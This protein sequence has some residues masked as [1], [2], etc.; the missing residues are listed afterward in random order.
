MKQQILRQEGQQLIKVALLLPV[1][2]A[3]LGLALDVGNVYVHHRMVQNAADAAA[4]AAGMVL[5]QSGASVAT[6]TARYY[7][8]LHGYDNN[9]T[10][11][12]V[13]VSVPPASG[14]YAGNSHYIQVRIQETIT[15]IFAALVWH[16]TF[17]VSASGTAGWTMTGLGPPVI[18][19][20]EHQC[21]TLRMNGITQLLVNMGSI[22]VNSN[23]PD[24]VRLVGSAS[25]ITSDPTTIVGGYSLGPGATIMPPPITGAPVLPDPLANLPVPDIGSYPVRYGTPSDP[26]TLKITSTSNVTLEPGVYYGGIEISGSGNVTFNPGVYILAGTGLKITG[27]GRVTGNNV[28]FYN[29]ND[30][31]KPT[32]DGAMGSIQLAGSNQL[33]LTPPGSGPYA[34]VTLFQD[35]S[36][37]NEANIVGSIMLSALNGIVYMKNG[38]LN[39]TGATDT[40]VNFVIKE[41]EIVGNGYLDVKGYEG[42]GWT[43]IDSRLSE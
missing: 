11:N 3:F 36:N 17:Q 28:F 31:S 34:G 40:Y 8:N 7:A 37:T 10:T 14:A 4:S 24:A 6:A 15:P 21:E 2:L 12:S 30:P 13:Q 20:E 5:Y 18:V 39:L 38:K 25:V 41:L 16:G 29:T 32:G 26:T 43:I 22:H 35:R 9:G 42:P 23:C 27:S 19:L 33:A 1:I